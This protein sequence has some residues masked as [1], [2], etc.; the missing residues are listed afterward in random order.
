MAKDI[1][2]KK[3]YEDLRIGIKNR[4]ELIKQ[5]RKDAEFA[6]GKQWKDDDKRTLEQRGVKAL[7]INK[8]KPMIKLITGIERQGRTDYKAFPEG[9]EDNLVSEIVTRLLKN[10]SKVSRVHN[11]I[12][13]QFKQRNQKLEQET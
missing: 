12:S 10:V 5:M 1:D 11:K 13:D 7:T 9:Q 6:L 3:V 2:V 8:I 4:R